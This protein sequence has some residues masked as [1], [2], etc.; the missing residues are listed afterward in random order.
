MQEFYDVDE[1][2]VVLIVSAR[3]DNAVVLFE[4]HPAHPGG[5]TFIGGRS[6]ARA[7]LTPKVIERIDARQA[8]VLS[9]AEAEQ[10]EQQEKV[11]RE[12]ERAQARE[13]ER[14]RRRKLYVASVGTDKGFDALY[15]P[16]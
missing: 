6:I 5:E 2:N 4:K 8:R 3:E 10:F 15:K 14:E 9:D 11:T 13:D 16:A 12:L 1:H 7:A